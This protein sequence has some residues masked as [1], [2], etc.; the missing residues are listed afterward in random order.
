[1]SIMP[2]YCDGVELCAHSGLDSPKV[3]PDVRKGRSGAA[4][5]RKRGL[6]RPALCVIC[7]KTLSL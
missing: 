7:E 5:L 6:Q 4:A 3:V 2:P 1:M